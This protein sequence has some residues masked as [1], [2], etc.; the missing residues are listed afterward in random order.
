MSLKWLGAIL[1][2]CGCGSIGFAMA[3]SYRGEERE[4]RRLTAALDYMS[5][6]L[7]YHM[8]PLPDLCRQ[9]AAEVSGT[10]GAIL[11]A[12]AEELE[13]QLLP[14]VGSCIA[15]ALSRTKNI[16]S[17]LQDAFDLLGRSLG[18]FDLEGQLTGIQSVREYC[19][20]QL[21]TMADGREGRLRSYQTLGLCAGAALAVLLV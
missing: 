16:P 19:R 12:L 7:Q 14:D 18:R 9:S 15:S 17:C 11:A 8:T 3:A 10:S 20:R 1:I 21:E 5:C 13:N 4:L 2:I 6:E